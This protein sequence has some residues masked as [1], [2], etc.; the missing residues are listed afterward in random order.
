MRM[1]VIFVITNKN[2]IIITTN[3]LKCLI[4]ERAPVPL[5]HNLYT[6]LIAADISV[7]HYLHF[8]G[9]VRNPPVFRFLAMRISSWAKHGSHSLNF[10]RGILFVTFWLAEG[11]R[12][13]GSPKPCIVFWKSA[14]WF[15]RAFVSICFARWTYGCARCVWLF[16]TRF[17]KFRF[18]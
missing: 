10:S 2:I 1:T 6:H 12:V 5:K 15:P 17:A 16:A 9:F 14:K 8:E 18:A 3:I 4:T 11:V 13:V 7:R